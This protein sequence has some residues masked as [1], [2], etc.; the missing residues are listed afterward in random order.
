MSVGVVSILF[1]K[2][3]LAYRLP[4]PLDPEV[5]ADLRRR[6]DAHVEQ[7]LRS[8]L[9]GARLLREIA[10]SGLHLRAGASSV[11]DF[12]EACGLSASTARELDHLGRALDAHAGLA[13][14]VESGAMHVAN[15]EVIGRIT[16][17]PPDFARPGED[18]LALAEAEDPRTFLRR[19]QERR[20]EVR[21]GAPVRPL[22]AYMSERGHRV[23]E[24]ARTIVSRSAQRSL[25]AGETIEAL[26][27]RCLDSCDPRRERAGRR[28]VPDTA[29]IPGSRYVPAEV[30]R[31]V[32]LR[33]GDRCAVRGCSN[34]M[35]LHL[36]H[37]TPHREAGSRESDNL[38]LLCDR[39]H[40]LF[41]Q[42]LIKLIG[43]PEA[44]VFTTAD[45]KVIGEA[46]VRRAHA[47]ADPPVSPPSGG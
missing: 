12:A 38:D 36:S 7:R 11:T 47:A 41:E 1:V 10:R 33:S 16:K 29:A 26:A 8:D 19:F 4:P 30:R 35:F 23:F 5:A 45:G 21:Q 40:T 22:L 17:E 31:R 6:F 32:R 20:D 42:G 2:P 25:T 39:H 9:E 24:E 18:W 14:R 3:G 28:R 15:A 44:P 34:R 43:P 37:R 27:D 13:E 46:S